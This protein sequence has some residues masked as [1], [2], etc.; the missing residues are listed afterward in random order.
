MNNSN[1]M[2]TARFPVAGVHA[3]KANPAAN[4][5]LN[6]QE[7]AMLATVVK[8]DKQKKM[9]NHSPVIVHAHYLLPPL[10]GGCQG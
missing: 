9:S 2:E 8:P 1:D 5:R 4:V 3:S 10:P 6:S 7:T